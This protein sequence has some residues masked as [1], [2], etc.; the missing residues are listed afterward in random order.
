[1]RRVPVRVRAHRRVTRTGATNVVQHERMM[2]KSK[3]GERITLTVYRFDDLPTKEAKQKAI[4]WYRELVS[5]DSD[6]LH[7]F[8]EDVENQL[9]EIG[10][11]NPDVSYSLGY[12]QGDGVSFES[13]DIDLEKLFK[14]YPEL[15]KY[16]S[17]LK[18]WDEYRLRFYVYRINTH[19]AHENSVRVSYDFDSDEKPLIDL[20]EKLKDDLEIIKNDLCRKFEKQ[21]YDEITYR[22]S[23]EAIIEDIRANG[24]K[25]LKDGSRKY[26]V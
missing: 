7:F 9:A 23:D 20:I 21:G 17:L 25:F 5:E 22:T 11:E 2:K 19:Y 15:K 24:Y 12:S 6:L 4:Q 8:K 26:V 1:M 10:F 18:Y 14:T 16:S 3:I 13:K